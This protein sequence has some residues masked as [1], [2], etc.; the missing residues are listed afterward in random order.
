[1]KRMS[2]EQA[3]RKELKSR[4]D[5]YYD[6]DADFAEEARISIATFNRRKK[7]P[8]DIR[9]DEAVR[10]SRALHMSFSEFANMYQ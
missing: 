8:S 9:F 10:M 5:Q 2:K 4:I 7:I 6:T 3:F 1:M